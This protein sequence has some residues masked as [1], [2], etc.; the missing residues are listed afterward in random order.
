MYSKI[1]TL[2]CFSLFFFWF[3][4]L[5][6]SVSCFNTGRGNRP[7]CCRLPVCLSCLPGNPLCTVGIHMLIGGCPLVL[8][9]SKN[10]QSSL[11]IHV[12][13]VS[14]KWS[15][16]GNTLGFTKP[17]SFSSVCLVAQSCPTLCNPMDCRTPGFP[18]RHQLPKPTQTHVHQVGAAIQLS[19]LLLLPSPP[20][21]N[22]SRHQGLFQW[23]RSSHQV[24]KV[25][26][27]Q[28][29][30]QSFQ[31]IFMTDFL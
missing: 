27:F 16:N 31:W 19:C 2:F 4:F 22:L 14:A 26:E 3:F 25:L 17:P 30:H 7:P 1:P 15:I 8:F 13:N 18:V 24:A 11:A 20:T 21:F 10:T 29:Q 28:L 23:V 12:N 9:T 6:T 5:S